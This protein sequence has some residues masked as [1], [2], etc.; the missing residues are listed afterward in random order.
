MYDAGDYLSAL[1]RRALI[2][3]LVTRWTT[4]RVNNHYWPFKLLA[5]ETFKINPKHFQKEKKK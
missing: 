4:T 5:K 2:K 1:W 3:L